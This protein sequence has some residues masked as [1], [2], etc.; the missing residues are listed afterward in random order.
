MTRQPVTD[1]NLSGLRP[2]GVLGKRV[3]D[4]WERLDEHLRATLGDAA[5]DLFAEPVP[6]SMGKVSWYG[7]EG[8]VEDGTSPD[9]GTTPVPLTSL[10]EAKQAAVLDR[11][12]TLRGQIRGEIDNLRASGRREATDLADVLE[13]ALSLPAVKPGPDR[14]GINPLDYVHVVGD[15]PV[16]VN[17]GVEAEHQFASKDPFREFV[18]LSEPPPVKP[19]E[20]PA[21]TLAAAPVVVAPVAVDGVV[22]ESLGWLT[23]LLWLLFALLI[24]A[25]FYV[26]LLGC[27]L[28]RTGFLSN[29]CPVP[30]RAAPDTTGEDPDQRA[31]LDR[32]LAEFNRLPRC[33]TQARVTPPREEHQVEQD[34]FAERVANEGGRDGDVTV[35]LSWD[36]PSDL[37]LHVVCPDGTEINFQNARACGGELD[38]DTNAGS[39]RLPN[40]VEHTV[41]ETMPADGRYKVRVH[42]YTHRGPGSGP[43]PFKVQLKKGDEVIV[44]DGRVSGRELTDVLE[45][46]VP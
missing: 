41:F 28:D 22:T 25:I 46:T 39:Q 26:L 23:G 34:E 20:A 13:S 30:T 12:D 24:A 16:L 21:A 3:I 6:G 9:T 35:T 38:I 31:E 11:L 43:I 45:F 42:N 5:A 37:D 18:R 36:G 14:S 27:G 10:D 4:N 1:T 2:R 32:L 15:Q 40:P 44:Q 8:E 29:H 33:D 7:P 17:W 19:K